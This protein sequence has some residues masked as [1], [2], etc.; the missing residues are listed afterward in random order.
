MIE[1][2]RLVISEMSFRDIEEVRA[3]HNHPETLKWLSDTH[4]VSEVEQL[5]WFKGLQ[6]SS[7][8]KRFVSREKSENT[9]I[10]VFRLDRLDKRNSCAEVGL[11]VSYH[12][13][14]MG[15]AR[16]IYKALIPYLFNE[17]SLHRLSL[18]TLENNSAAI[19]LYESLG[20]KREG[21][22]RDALKRETSFVNAIQFSLLE[23]EFKI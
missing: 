18:I 14:R 5:Q 11:D 19:Q 20:F 16:E 17:I 6:G 9:L 23:S 2:Q 8:S 21:I 13:R 4:E 7:F 22:L 15:F 12:F 10:G 3:L 1:T